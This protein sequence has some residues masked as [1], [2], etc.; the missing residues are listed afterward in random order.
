VNHATIDRVFDQGLGVPPGWSRS[1][2]VASALVLADDHRDTVLTLPN[3]W[4]PCAA[5]YPVELRLHR[6]DGSEILR[7]E[8]VVGPRCT[9]D[10]S[11][12]DLLRGAGVE[13]PVVAH[14]EMRVGRVPSTDELPAV[15]DLVV[16]LHDDGEV[17][18]EV[19]V[20]GEFF[21]ADVP[22]GVSGPDIRRTR[23][24]TRVRHGGP[25]T[26][27]IYLAYP[28]PVDADPGI[29]AR[30]LLTL[31]DLTGRERA[32]AEVEV[33]IH[34]CVFADLGELFGPAAAE[35]LGN[36][37]AGALRVRDTTAR[38]YGYHLVEVPG[39]RSVTIDHLVGG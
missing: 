23:V 28:G 38:L 10:L 31:L 39:A 6:P 30:P 35:V 17:A 18:G 22:P 29:V 15:L 37:C 2:P 36:D 25:A 33:P 27:S 20:G 13:L 1:Q 26:T 7:H 9:V 24:F 34:G 3:V 4:G 5:S 12:R 8:V 21:N 11:M 32:T 16:G 19:Q 14:A